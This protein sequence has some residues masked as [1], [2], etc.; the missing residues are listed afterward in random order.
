MAAVYT[1]F[2]R[3]VSRWF[4]LLVAG[5]AAGCSVW[6][7]YTYA[8]VPFM[9][10]IAIGYAIWAVGLWVR[11]E[12]ASRRAWLTLGILSGFMLFLTPNA[13]FLAFCVWVWL[14]PQVL[15]RRW[16]LVNPALAAGVALVTGLPMLIQWGQGEGGQL[17]SLVQNPG[18]TAEKVS[19]FLREAAF[20][21][22]DSPIQGAGAFG[23][24]LPPYFRW[25]FIPGIL[26][27]PLVPKRFAP[28]A[29]LVLAFYVVQVLILAFAQGP[30]SSVSVKRA[31]ILIPMAT[32][33]AFLPFH[34]LLRHLPV[35][36]VLI[37]AWS[38]FGIADV[39]NRMQPGRTGY[40]FLDGVIEAHQRFDDAPLC[41]YVS[42]REF[43]Q[44][45]DPGTPVDRLFNLTP[46]VEIVGDTAHPACRRTLCYQPFIDTLDLPGLG[47]T[48]VPMLGSVELRC[49][50][51]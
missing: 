46:R 20:I 27:T 44:H 4:G 31:L 1:V 21:P 30:Y 36:L 45:F 12:P 50:R 24:Q 3:L 13:W 25:L 51:R 23:P 5:C 2:A 48:E 7:V 39:V 14:G 49:G 10:G 40:T 28:G 6:I 38:A 18:W 8:S 11:R 47:Y 43:T 35:V 26:L 32:Y 42:K 19:R 29:R 34:R 22:F 17:F 15:W 41:V 9:D 33:F 37:T 16:G